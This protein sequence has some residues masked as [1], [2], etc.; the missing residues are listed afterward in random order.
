[1]AQIKGPSLLDTFRPAI[2]QNYPDIVFRP[3]NFTVGQYTFSVGS[4]SEW[5]LL[6]VDFD[7][8]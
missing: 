3:W 8:I 7:N 2:R 6:G 4:E 5:N 1:M